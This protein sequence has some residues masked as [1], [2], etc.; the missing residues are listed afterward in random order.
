RK[1]KE[2]NR[3][4]HIMGNMSKEKYHNVL[5]YA[6]YFLHPGCADNGNGTAFDAAMLGVP[7][8]SCDD[9][10][11]RN[12]DE[13]TFFKRACRLLGTCRNDAFGCLY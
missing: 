5:K 3:H 4:I 10:A 9:P 11:M 12:M 13:K 1:N 6:K 7:T 2:L 8:L